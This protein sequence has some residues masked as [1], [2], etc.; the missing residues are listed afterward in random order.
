MSAVTGPGVPVLVRRRTALET[1]W[2]WLALG[3]VACGALGGLVA[4]SGEP[5]RGYTVGGL[6]SGGAAVGCTLLAL[7]YSL[8]KRGMQEAWPIGRGTMAAWLWVHVAFG[9]IALV[10][11]VLHA[12]YGL[13]SPTFSSGKLIVLVFVLVSLSGIAWRI[14]YAVVPP[15]AAPRIHNYSQAQSLGRAEEQ[16]TELEKLAAGKSAGFRDLRDWIVAEG[17][18]LQRVLQAGAPLPPEERR[19]LEDLHRVGGSLRRALERHRLQAR[20][21]RILQGWRLLH[22][23]L[24]FALVPLIAFHAVAALEL[25]A[26]LAPLGSAGHGAWSGVPP[27]SECRECHRLI[28]DQW[29]TSMHAHALTSPVTI[30]QNNQLLRAELDQKASPD[31][32]QICVNCHAP[33]GAA[34]ARDAV[35]PL[36]RS[37]YDDAVLNDGVSCAACHQQTGPAQ[38][39][40]AAG[41][42]RFQ[43]GF[44]PGEP[45]DG[46][47]G[48][49]VGN[50][51]HRSTSTA[52]FR[53]PEK[54]CMSC[55]NVHYDLN[56]DGKIVKGVDL[57]L[58]STHE[59]H[60]EYAAEGG[61]STCLGCH[62]PVVAG[63]TRAAESAAIPFEQDEEA[64]PRVIHDH[65]F[66]G[67]DYP[68]DE[69]GRKDPHREDRAA[70]LRSAARLELDEATAGVIKAGAA[71]F[72]VSVT[73][74]GAGH[75][76]PTG[77]AFAR[78][79]WIEVKVDAGGV[80]VL[81]S[82][83][84]AAPTD[85][86]C[87]AATLDDP[88]NPLLPHVTGCGASDPQLVSFQQKLVDRIDVARDAAGR[89]LTNDR[90][91]LKV[92]QAEGARE[93]V[94][95]RLAGGPVTRVRPSDKQPLG[96]IPPNDTRSFEYRA[97][98]PGGVSSVT[99]SVRLLFR[100]LPPYMVRALA[101]GQ[102]PGEEPKLAPLVASLQ[103]VEMASL[104]RT[105]AL[106]GR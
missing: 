81:T 19:E 94:L 64:P 88:G 104:R 11:T 97:P 20:Y 3:L 50:A 44:T 80:P 73:N 31:P 5:L 38:P 59:E 84:L 85:D 71:T 23:P 17:P 62:M 16:R 57:V 2:P 77:F 90:G 69:V 45:Y 27:S 40:G 1:P 18:S 103:V 74:T 100:N 21:T 39:P 89:Q 78:Q 55:H 51:Y 22:V 96:S 29:A 37:S 106:R 8:R 12:G 68:L 102:L 42:T 105:V 56:A 28:H 46:P 52:L 10:A 34:L 13:I 76:L 33:I 66:V 70:L 54:L 67:V 35:L 32:R 41:F 101:A 79:L 65:S 98:V 25:P 48:D 95:Q 63:R 75:N 60:L 15:I 47:I 24:T 30:A 43:R 86:L 53:Q 83:A 26:R 4:T 6:V 82:G 92:I 14:V 58:Q 61:R 36:R 72:T 91:E 49:P 7:L 9:A 93:T 99:V 87:D